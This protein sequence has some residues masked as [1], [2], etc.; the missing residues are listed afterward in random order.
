MRK[1]VGE[2]P[3]LPATDQHPESLSSLSPEDVGLVD[4][5]VE[6]IKSWSS[7]HTSYL[8]AALLLNMLSTYIARA[9]I[10]KTE[11]E[12][13]A[14][15]LTVAFLVTANTALPGD[16]LD[17]HIQPH[18]VARVC[19]PDQLESYINT[20]KKS[21]ATSDNPNLPSLDDLRPAWGQVLGTLEFE[22]RNT[23]KCDIGNYM[24]V[25]KMYRVDLPHIIGLAACRGGFNL[26]M[27]C[28]N[29]EM[30]ASQ[31]DY[32]W[33][34]YQTLMRYVKSLYL[35]HRAKDPNFDCL[36]VSAQA[37][38]CQVEGKKYIVFPFYAT[39]APGRCTWVAAGADLKTRKPVV[40][41]VYWADDNSHA[42]EGEICEKLKGVKDVMQPV[43]FECAPDVEKMDWGDKSR[44][45]Y[46]LLTE[47]LGLPLSKCEK[48][49]D[50]LHLM[51]DL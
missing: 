45:K 11:T 47:D 50:F 29:V 12:N 15:P 18:M 46:Y 32:A 21:M 7:E 22:K 39:R 20:L 5:L 8:S 4:K 27:L 10:A 40:L 36:P 35:C 6:K 16:S 28:P 3:W 13:S 51:I 24:W 49:T 41:K 33:N 19:R 48:L 42:I 44:Q 31:E 2:Q 14:K 43:A 30:Q 17:A 34:D 1:D 37:W 38:V 25:N 23:G 9:E 26:Y